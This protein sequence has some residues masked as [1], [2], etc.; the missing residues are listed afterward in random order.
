[1]SAIIE[2]RPWLV[3]GFAVAFVLM[4]WA[5]LA[6]A[7]GGLDV[8]AA[9]FAQAVVGFGAMALALV[10][11]RTV[12]RL[13]VALAGEVL[14]VV[15]A[16]GVGTK[17]ASIPLG[18]IVWVD[19]H[20]D[21]LSICTVRSD[22]VFRAPPGARQALRDAAAELQQL[23]GPLEASR[24][25]LLLRGV[26]V[27]R[28]AEGF[29][30]RFRSAHSGSPWMLVVLATAP[31]FLLTSFGVALLAVAQDLSST[32]VAVIVAVMVAGL[33]LPLVCVPW[34]MRS[35]RWV[36]LDWSGS[37]LQVQEQTL[38]TTVTEM[39]RVTGARAERGALVVY[40]SG[41]ETVV[42]VPTASRRRLEALRW[43]AE[44]LSMPPG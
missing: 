2:G 11:S 9:A 43:A 14:R 8:S 40:A 7:R 3:R 26:L 23:V 5:M 31:A 32:E 24:R 34:L 36:S 33:L 41:G 19:A 22:R 10:L 4:G 6:S 17:R 37:T 38:R 1:M 30:M 18:D 44:Q 35:P 16:R 21:L 42:K 15:C 28:G 29:H 12:V 13:E 25:A 27:E 39:E 20:G